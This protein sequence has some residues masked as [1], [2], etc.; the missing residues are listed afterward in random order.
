MVPYPD[1]KTPAAGRICRL[2]RTSPPEGQRIRCAEEVCKR[3]R[4]FSI[5]P[6]AQPK[7]AAG[8]TDHCPR[9]EGDSGKPAEKSVCPG[10]ETGGRKTGRNL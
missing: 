6:A 2:Y 8:E 7:N 9:G 1:T 5:S 3:M 10:V 4:F